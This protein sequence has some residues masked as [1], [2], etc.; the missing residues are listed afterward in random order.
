MSL[1]QS[2]CCSIHVKVSLCHLHT[3]L[4]DYCDSFSAPKQFDMVMPQIH[5]GHQ[6]TRLKLFSNWIGHLGTS[7]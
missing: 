3:F 1:P 4:H 2:R 6:K 5:I 7:L